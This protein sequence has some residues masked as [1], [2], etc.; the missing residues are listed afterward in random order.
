MPTD[1]SSRVFYMNEAAFELP[2]LPFV[3]RT[4][5]SLD[6]RTPSGEEI[7]LRVHRSPLAPGETLRSVVAAHVAEA[8]RS[9]PSYAL[10]WERDAELA[11][12]PAIEL[13]ARWR[14]ESSMLYSRQAHFAVQT[15][16]GDA[17][18]GVQGL[19]VLISV[20][21]ALAETDACDACLEHV[22]ATLR[23]AR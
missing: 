21:G 1:P 20:N 5:T 13:A 9:L 3:D 17:P 22:V 15:P 11:G 18:S 12:V 16:G 10:L 8:T 2:D 6:A 14:G 7:G 23:L 4:V 19:W